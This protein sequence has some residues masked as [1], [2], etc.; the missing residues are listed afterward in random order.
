MKRQQ[1][2]KK[3]YRKPALRVHG[4]VRALTRAKAGN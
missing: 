3:T 2:D 4:D 1:K